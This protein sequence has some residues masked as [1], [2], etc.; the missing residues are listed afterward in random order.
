[1]DYERK[2]KILQI[3]LQKEKVQHN[4]L[5]MSPARLFCAEPAAAKFF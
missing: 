2:K 3:P 1:M 5:R 4:P